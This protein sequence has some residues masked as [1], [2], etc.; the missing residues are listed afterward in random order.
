[1]KD[2]DFLRL[3]QVQDSLKPFLRLIHSQQP[4]GGWIR[5]IREALG[6]TTVQLAKRLNV[7]PQTLDDLE[8]N[9]VR[10][11]ITL[12]SLNKLARALDCRV[13]YAV[14]PPKPL[15]QMQRDRARTIA[16]NQLERVSH[17]MKLEA[18]DVSVHEERRQLE[19]L[20]DK[21]LSGNP[22]KLWD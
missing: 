1:M 4:S 3:N 17:S 18:Q 2:N 8:A 22:K 15:G 10:G 13:V 16:R 5:S 14:I 20:V 11:K 19:R 6:M 21:I 12:E 9:E 7:K